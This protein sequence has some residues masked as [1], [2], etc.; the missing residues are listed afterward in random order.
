MKSLTDPRDRA[1]LLERLQ[2]V[3]SGER[4]SSSPPPSIPGW[5]QRLIKF[6][7]LELPFSWPRGVK[8]RPDVDQERGGTR[9][10]DF[11]A[12]VAELVRACERFATGRDVRGPHCLFGPLTDDEW[13]RW[14]YRHVDHHLRQFGV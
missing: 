11:A 12:D 13:G 1:A 9:P 4:P 7:A 6:V 14:G 8:T 5:R 10:Q 3:R 2:H